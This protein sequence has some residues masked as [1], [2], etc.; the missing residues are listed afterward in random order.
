[1][2]AK[3]LIITATNNRPNYLQE[4]LASVRSQTEADY[5]QVV[6]NNGDREP[7]ASLVRN[8][9]KSDKRV[10]YVEYFDRKGGAAARNKGLEFITPQTQFIKFLDDDDIFEDQDSLKILVEAI[11][12]QDEIGFVYARQRRVRAD[13]SWINVTDQGPLGLEYILREAS[14]PF[15]STIFRRELIEGVGG[16]SPWQS[17]EDLELVCRAFLFCANEGMMAKY[18]DRIVARYRW[19]DDGLRVRNINSGAKYEAMEQARKKFDPVLELYQPT[20]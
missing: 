11:E 1:M 8:M 13:G 7:T 18:L 10:K 4:T 14:F 17:A 12:A 20:V 16:F 6:V 9:S 2:D 15:T 5:L 19:H 3:T